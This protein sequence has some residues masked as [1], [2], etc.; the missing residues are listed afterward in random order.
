MEPYLGTNFIQYFQWSSWEIRKNLED[1]IKYILLSWNTIP[2]QQMVNV[3]RGPSCS[4]SGIAVCQSF[5]SR[6][7]HS[8]KICR[9]SRASAQPAQSSGMTVR[10]ESLGSEGNRAKEKLYDGHILKTTLHSALVKGYLALYYK[11]QSRN[12]VHFLG[13]QPGTT[14]HLFTYIHSLATVYNLP[15]NDATLTP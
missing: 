3:F 14:D 7:K 8:I 10:L 15:H 12:Y 9:R 4:H 1:I 2:V 11:T 13:I 6:S 5:C